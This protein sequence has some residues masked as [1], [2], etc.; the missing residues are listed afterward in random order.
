[1]VRGLVANGGLP[2]T[3]P[4]GLRR[5][6]A[7]LRNIDAFFAEPDEATYAQGRFPWRTYLSR[8]FPITNPRS[9]DF[10]QPARFI[11]KVF[12]VAESTDSAS[13]TEEFI[14]M[15][16]PAGRV[17]LKLLVARESDQVKE[18]WIER[19]RTYADGTARVEPILNL[20][21]EA[22]SKLVALLARLH[23][24]DIEGPTTVRIDDS[25]LDEVLADPEAVET[26]YKRNREQFRELIASDTSANDLIALAN[27]RDQIAYF[28]ELLSDDALFE[29]QRLALGG[30]PEKVWQEFFE[31]NPWMLGVGLSSQ[32]LTSWSSTK[33]EQVVSGFDIAGAGKRTDAL[34]RTA[35]GI[36]HMVFAEIKHHRT[37]LLVSKPY[38]PACWSPSSEL[39]GGVVQIQQT[40]YRATAEI[41]ESLDELAE[42]GSTTGE[43]TYLHRPRSFLIIGRTSEL[44]GEAGGVHKDKNRS[45]EVYRRNLYEP[46]VVTFDEVLARAEW[47]VELA[48]RARVA[49]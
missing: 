12:D 19:V 33:L 49:Q 39:S 30:G 18:L 48:S 1:M 11:S 10:G 21:R 47:Q 29:E 37:P 25:L 15:T 28:Q 45:F 17:Q 32:L 5:P 44:R 22:A 3:E 23:Q 8:S 38:R 4:S 2:V 7:D 9:R 16:S 20:Q 14:V 42:D 24:F 31:T 41:G 40:V 26:A 36:R 6:F 46:E 35:G 27:R 43:S 34:M 13:A